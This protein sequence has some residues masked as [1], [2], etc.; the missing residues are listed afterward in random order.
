ME[1]S[2]TMR[3]ANREGCFEGTLPRETCKSTMPLKTELRKACHKLEVLS[4]FEYA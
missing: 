1:Y 2:T 4:L 3:V